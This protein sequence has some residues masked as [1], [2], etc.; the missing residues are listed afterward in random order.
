MTLELEPGYHSLVSAIVVL[1]VNDIKAGAAILKTKDKNKLR[2]S[3][4]L[5]NMLEAEWFMQSEWFFELTDMDGRYILERIRKEL[6]LHETD[7]LLL[8]QLQEED[9]GELFTEVPL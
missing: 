6:G 8:R 9:S 7:Y 3:T 2:K 4:R 1:A 5:M